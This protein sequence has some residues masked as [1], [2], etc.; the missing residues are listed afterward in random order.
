M[1]KCMK[2]ESN[3]RNDEKC[4]FIMETADLAS[5]GTR[6]GKS[7]R[8]R[9]NLPLSFFSPPPSSFLIFTIYFSPTAPSIWVSRDESLESYCNIM[10]PPL[11]LLSL[12]NPLS[13]P[14]IPGVVRACPEIFPQSRSQVFDWLLRDTRHA[15]PPPLMSVLRWG[16]NLTGTTVQCS[17]HRPRFWSFHRWAFLL[18]VMTTTICSCCIKVPLLEFLTVLPEGTFSDTRCDGVRGMEQANR[19]ST[20]R[21]GSEPLQNLTQ[22]HPPF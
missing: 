7:L 20:K 19:T 2:K 8:N 4:P 5:G 15:P 9:F 12:V 3:V 1:C 14:L 13:L 6:W 21:R 22:R 11:V 10:F 16:I 17:Y 18:V